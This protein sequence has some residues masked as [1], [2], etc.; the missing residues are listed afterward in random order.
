MM[1]RRE[2]YSQVIEVMTGRTPSQIRALTANEYEPS[3]NHARTWNSARLE[4][5]DEWKMGVTDLGG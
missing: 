2:A 5:M 1:G 4:R 3:P